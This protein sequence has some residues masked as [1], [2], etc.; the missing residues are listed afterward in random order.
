MA[1]VIEIANLQP[2]A[3]LRARGEVQLIGTQHGVALG[4][5]GLAQLGDTGGFAGAEGGS[6]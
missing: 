3:R 6:E 5:E 4:D 2:A 1:A